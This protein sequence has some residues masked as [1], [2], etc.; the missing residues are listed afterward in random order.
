MT[1]TKLLTTGAVIKWSELTFEDRGQ[2]LVAI[3][4]SE[5]KGATLVKGIVVRI[6]PGGTWT[7]CEKGKAQEVVGVIWKGKGSARVGE[8]RSSL[9]PSSALY[10]PSGVEYEVTAD[11]GEEITL[12]IW[13]SILPEG[14]VVASKPKLFNSLYN[15]ETQ[16]KGFTGNDPSQKIENPANMNFL[17][18]PGTGSA[19]LSL[20]CGIQQPGQ[21]FAV[22][23]HPHSSELFIGVEGKGEIYLD[24]EWHPFEAG[25]LLYV[26]QGIFHGTRNL[27]TGEGAARFVTTGGPTPFDASFYTFAGVSPEV[28]NPS[29]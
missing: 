12:Y 13:Q 10:A 17:F 5:E 26:P 18:W 8:E 11:Q 15:E 2:L 4:V 23:K 9:V 19:R 29:E 25:D 22:H 14:S 24:G 7:S 16:L 6:K 27:N 21:S 1:A 28:R 3:P 20:H